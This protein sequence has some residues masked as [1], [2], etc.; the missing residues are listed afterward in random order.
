MK[1]PK[2]L[3]IKKIKARLHYVEIREDDLYEE[4]EETVKKILK[5][6]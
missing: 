4:I 1:I 3:I 2:N 6:S 5:I